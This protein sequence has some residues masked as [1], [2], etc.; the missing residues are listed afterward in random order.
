MA[1]QKKKFYQ[2]WW[3]WLI[4]GILVLGGIGSALGYGDKPSTKDTSIVKETSIAKVVPT[5]KETT[6]KETAIFGNP[7][8]LS[9]GESYNDNNV[10]ITIES[11]ENKDSQTNITIAF[12]NRSKDKYTA[13]SESFRILDLDENEQSNF[14][15][16]SNKK[17][18]KGNLQIKAGKKKT[19]I[20]SINQCDIRTITYSPAHDWKKPLAIWKVATDK[21][22]KKH[23]AEMKELTQSVEAREKARA[24]LTNTIFLYPDSVQW[25]GLM[26]SQLKQGKGYYEEGTVKYKNQLGNTVKSQ[27]KIWYKASGTVTAAE[28]DGKPMYP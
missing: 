23:D 18:V 14:Q 17:L 9:P 5:E 24:F 21:E 19:E 4:V 22:I 13:S 25:P 27:Y 11:V 10:V 6:Q 8:N 1:T 12:D 3:F 28:I 2:K 7:L 15:K 20:L 26:Y 16:P